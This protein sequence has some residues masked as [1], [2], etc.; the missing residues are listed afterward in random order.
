MLSWASCYQSLIWIFDLALKLKINLKYLSVL[1]LEIAGVVVAVES[2]R[3]SSRDNAWRA[4]NQGSYHHLR[5]YHRVK[6]SYRQIVV[7]KPESNLNWRSLLLMTCWRQCHETIIVLVTVSFS[8]D[9][10]GE[11]ILLI[12]WWQ[13]FTVYIGESHVVNTVVRCHVLS[14]DTM[15]SM[16]AKLKQ[17]CPCSKHGI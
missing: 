3:E 14:A 4:N 12:H 6:F 13:Q 11:S 15:C 1:V 7:N 2:Y 16:I 8:K 9:K 10:E 5:H 17:S